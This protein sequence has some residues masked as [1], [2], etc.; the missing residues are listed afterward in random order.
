[1]ATD[2]LLAGKGGAQQNVDLDTK[3]ALTQE[4]AMVP[5]VDEVSGTVIYIGLALPGTAKSAALWQIKKLNPTGGLD[6]QY[7]DGDAEFDNVWDDR[8]AL[9]YS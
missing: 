7:A 1:M 9:S 3:A 6:T 5:L 4:P 8:A 2:I